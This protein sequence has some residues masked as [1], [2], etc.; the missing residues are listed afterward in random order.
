MLNQTKR[1]ISFVITVIVITEFDCLYK[2]IE[3]TFLDSPVLHRS[4]KI[5]ECI[6]LQTHTSIRGIGI[7][8]LTQSKGV[9]RLAISG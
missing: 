8:N 5:L 7:E 6:D 1:S 2:F 4:G 9:S 3:D